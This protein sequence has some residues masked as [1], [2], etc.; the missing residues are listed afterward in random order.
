MK[1]VA[2]AAF[3][4]LVAALYAACGR[5]INEPAACPGTGQADDG[6]CCPAWTR[7]SSGTC[8]ARDVTRPEMW[9]SVGPA[10]ARGLVASVAENGQALLAWT[11]VENTTSRLFVGEELRGGT[12]VSTFEASRFL[13]GNAVQPTLATGLGSRAVL[14][15]KEEIG[16]DASGIFVAERDRDGR[17]KLPLVAG[18]TL[19]FEPRAFEPFALTTPRGEAVLVWNQWFADENIYGVEVA[20]HVGDDAWVR[21][22]GAG[23]IL[24][25]HVKYANTPRAAADADGDVLV[26]WYQAKHD[27][28]LMAWF[29]ERAGASGT[30]TRATDDDHLS[31][32]GADVGA[33]GGGSP[34]PV[35]GAHGDAYVAWLQGNADAHVLPYLATRDRGGAW[36]KPALEDA[37]GAPN[38]H[39]RELALALGAQGA[40]YLAWTQDE[41]SGAV[42]HA[43]AR[44]ADGTWREDPHAPPLVSSAGAVVTNPVLAAGREGGVLLAW[45]EVGSGGSALRM[46]RAW[47]NGTNDGTGWGPIETVSTPDRFADSPAIAFGGSPERVVIAFTEGHDA[48]VQLASIE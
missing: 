6:R 13:H 40:L 42:L 11:V 26:T 12:G 27:D 32:L 35:L 16:T 3:V 22:A 1:R 43:L 33:Q 19:S 41:G 45:L 37:L 24:S 18:D 23:D 29:A 7:V 15:W 21:P 5:V 17:W 9:H 25:P 34:R 10:G 8:R 2:A 46:R 28:R 47:D 20:T 30:F 39:A 4:A 14:A 31:P 38:G 44:N 36:K 48:R